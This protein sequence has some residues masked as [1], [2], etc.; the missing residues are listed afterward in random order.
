M[1]LET[2]QDLWEYQNP[3]G[4]YKQFIKNKLEEDNNQRLKVNHPRY[5]TITWDGINLKTIEDF[6]QTT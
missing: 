5:L 3:N 4:N 6:L 1:V 2:L